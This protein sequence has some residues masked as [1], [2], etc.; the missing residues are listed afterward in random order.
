[1][2]VINVFKNI[3]HDLNYT[4]CKHVNMVDFH[5]FKSISKYTSDMDIKRYCSDADIKTQ[6]HLIYA[7]ERG[8]LGII[9]Y[10]FE[11]YKYLFYK[12]NNTVNVAINASTYGHHDM[13]VFLHKMGILPFVTNIVTAAAVHNHCNI[14]KYLYNKCG[15]I[16]TYYDV[17]EAYKYAAYNGNMDIIKFFHE[18]KVCYEDTVEI[19]DKVAK[20]NKLDMLEYLYSIGGRCSNNGLDNAAKHGNLKVVEYLKSVGCDGSPQAIKN[21]V[22]FGY[23]D[24]VKL[25]R[26]SSIIETRDTLSIAYQYGYDE[27]ISYLESTR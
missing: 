3:S 11:N 9:K 8:Y 26:T 17:Y 20:Y 15:N 2:S 5:S 6:F 21:A 1:M 18:K 12:A 16:Y 14:I 13:I 7:S 4:I 22:M 23:L 25:L 24:I 27:I 19:M 10:L